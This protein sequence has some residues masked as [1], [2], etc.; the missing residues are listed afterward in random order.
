MHKL[1]IDRSI[2]LFKILFL[3][4]SAGNVNLHENNI[5]KW[6]QSPWFGCDAHGVKSLVFHHGRILTLQLNY[7]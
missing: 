1:T 3:T 4:A 5:Q 7:K 2:R 6:L